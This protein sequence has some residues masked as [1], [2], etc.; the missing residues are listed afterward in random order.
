C[1]KRYEYMP[2]IS[3]L[4]KKIHEDIYG[5]R[6]DQVIITGY[7]KE[8]WLFHPVEGSLKDLFGI[9]EASKYI[10][11][12]P[13]FRESEG[14]ALSNL[15]EYS[16]G[17]DTGLPVVDSREKMEEINDLLIDNDMVLLIKLHPF[18]KRSAVNCEGFS[19]ISIIENS[20]LRDKDIEINKLM[21]KADAFISDYS[22]AAIDYLVLD[23]PMAFVIEDVEEYSKSRGFVFDPV[24]DYFPGS[25]IF[26]FEDMLSFV[27][28]IA[29]GEDPSKEKREVLRNKMHTYG[30][31]QSS[32]R[33]VD[34][35]KI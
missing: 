18:Q 25:E 35:L 23:R 22:S 14:K 16:I 34:F 29:K 15:N 19:N 13:T 4:Y 26:T 6:D 8:D 10:I 31:D 12:M 17:G 30:D 11:W 5:L 20:D 2:V 21:P 28:S 1:E 7:P 27:N 3:P 9:K 24:R 32:K 33:I